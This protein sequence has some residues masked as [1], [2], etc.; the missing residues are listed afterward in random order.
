MNENVRNI[1]LYGEPKT[2][3]TMRPAQ[4]VNVQPRVNIKGVHDT[5]SN[6]EGYHAG[7]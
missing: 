3:A 2:N 4:R 5:K 7:Q 1:K 6:N